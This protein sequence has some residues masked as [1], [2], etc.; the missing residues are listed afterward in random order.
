MSLKSK[1]RTMSNEKFVDDGLGN[2]DIYRKIISP[3]YPEDPFEVLGERNFSAPRVVSETE[4]GSPVQ[5]FYRNSTIFLT[6]GTGFVGLLLTEKLLRCCPHVKRI[7]TLVR[8]KRNKSSRERYDEYFKN[9][10]SIVCN[11]FFD[12][13][14]LGN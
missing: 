4:V 2:E 7:Y 10:V 9:D 8:A 6:G 5:E 13:R 3:K 14:K 11:T 1:S 12:K